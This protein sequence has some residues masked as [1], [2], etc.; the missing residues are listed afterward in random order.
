M[1]I[2]YAMYKAVMRLQHFFRTSRSCEPRHGTTCTAPERQPGQQVTR[3]LPRSSREQSAA[4]EQTR[5]V[6]NT[7]HVTCFLKKPTFI[8]GKEA[9]ATVA[10]VSRRLQ[11]NRNCNYTVH[12]PNTTVKSPLNHKPVILKQ[13]M[14]QNV[15]YLS[16][17][18][19]QLGI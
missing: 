5:L 9:P 14:S 10:T 15:T 16:F 13:R 3:S 11:I 6:S 1:P 8:S 2:T 19:P 18:F 12:R 4:S 17:I 7:P